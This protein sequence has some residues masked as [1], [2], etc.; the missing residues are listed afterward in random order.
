MLSNLVPSLFKPDN[1]R[2]SGISEIN[3]I[4]HSLRFLLQLSFSEHMHRIAISLPCFIP[5]NIQFLKK[6]CWPTEQLAQIY[7]CLSEHFCSCYIKVS[8]LIRQT[9]AHY[10]ANQKLLNPQFSGKP[11]EQPLFLS[12][13]SQWKWLLI[14]IVHNI[15]L[16]YFYQSTKTFFN[17]K[18]TVKA[19]GSSKR[20]LRRTGN[21]K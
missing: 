20:T 6:K 9:K 1:V 8:N 10:S 7:Q 17:C 11:L 12:S 5:Q 3:T 16:V 21:C 13:T 15:S 14:R 2:Q 4:V 18:N 19:N